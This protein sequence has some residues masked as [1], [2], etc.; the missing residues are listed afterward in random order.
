MRNTLRAL[1]PGLELVLAWV[2][3]RRRQMRADPERGSPTLETIVVAAGLF[4][5]ASAVVAAIV[6]AVNKYMGKIG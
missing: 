2:G 4:L 3:V 6:A 1:I 5:A